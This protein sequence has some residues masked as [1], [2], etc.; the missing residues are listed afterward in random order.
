[1]HTVI[2]A[3]YCLS[4]GILHM[5]NQ[6][7]KLLL[8]TQFMQWLSRILPPYTINSFSS[9]CITLLHC[10]ENEI[11]SRNYNF[12]SFLLKTDWICEAASFF[13]Q[14]A[15][16]P[17]T[18]SHYYFLHRHKLNLYILTER[19]KQNKMEMERIHVL[20]VFIVF[21]LILFFSCTSM[22]HWTV[23]C[24]SLKI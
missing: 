17:S 2:V 10:T 18:D 6:H 19:K 13:E 3:K 20:A 22:H 23:R 12:A 8:C 1:M 7:R 5:L 15:I 16:S 9:K 21:A 14:I 11:C 24:H 4:H